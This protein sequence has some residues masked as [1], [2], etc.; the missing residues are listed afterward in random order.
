M[1]II[2]RNEMEADYDQ[3]YEV[4]LQA[5]NS[6]AEPLIV[7]KLRSS[8]NVI[9]LVALV[10]SQIVGHIIFSPIKVETGF[11]INSSDVVALGPMSVSP[12][13]QNIKIGSKLVRRGIEECK[14]KKYKLVVVLGHPNFYPK[15]GFIEAQPK[16]I[17]C[18]WDVSSEAWMLIELI[19]GITQEI[20][21]KAIYDNAFS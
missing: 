14:S 8:P 7:T 1:E 19:E 15:F 13:F 20:K 9:S 5:F 21:G 16:G 2:I 17:T 12:K 4:N 18:Q 3:V 11:G 6:E 10:D